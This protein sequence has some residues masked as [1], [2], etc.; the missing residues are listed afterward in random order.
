MTPPKTGCGGP[1]TLGDTSL[2]NLI[3]KIGKGPKLSSDLGR[4]EAHAA[5]AQILDGTA[6]PAQTGAF[7]VALR[8]KGESTDEISGF[9]DALRER[10]QLLK[11]GFPKLLELAPAHDGKTRSHVLSPFVACAIAKAG[12]P[13]VVSGADAVPTKKGM[14]PKHIFTALG[15]AIPKT[16]L[17]VLDALKQHSV[18]YYDTSVFCPTL[19]KL[20]P[21]R[22]SLGL[23]TPLNT[24]EKIINPSQATHLA[25]GVFHGPYLKTVAEA[26]LSLGYPNALCLQASEASTDLPLK[27]RTLY[28][29]VQNN[30]LTEQLE[31]DP[32]TFG[33]KRD[34]ETTLVEQSANATV[35]AVQSAVNAKSGALYDAL[36]YN[37]A[38]QLWFVGA[39][40]NITTG[41]KMARELAPLLRPC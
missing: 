32:A 28:R 25:T 19:E 9:A 10:S 14:A 39:V 3:K 2:K 35:A 37:I 17:E 1:V 6:E 40:E 41:I 8:M 38:V 24:V 7:L 26:A 29:Q 20:K 15:F 23:R 22:D 12:I 18:A 5:L 13:V 36:I 34:D 16:S 33:L 21:L 11:H 27:K 30:T 31:I 4:E